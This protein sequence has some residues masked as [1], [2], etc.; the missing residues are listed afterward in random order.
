MAFFG[1]FD[2]IPLQT[3]HYGSNIMH[4][5]VWPPR[6]TGRICVEYSSLVRDLP[7]VGPFLFRRNVMRLVSLDKY[8]HVLRPQ[9]S[10]DI[11]KL[12]QLVK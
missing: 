5:Y 6:R 7:L 2:I 4:S 9:Y 1:H 10:T 3:V 11:D 12:I 8:E